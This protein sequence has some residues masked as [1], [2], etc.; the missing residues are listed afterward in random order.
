MSHTSGPLTVCRTPIVYDAEWEQQTPSQLRA[1][2]LWRRQ[3]TR[4]DGSLYP[5]PEKVRYED[6][7]GFSWQVDVKHAQPTGEV[8]VG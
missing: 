4:R 6:P 5:V 3:W 8:T 2:V 7:D 1:L